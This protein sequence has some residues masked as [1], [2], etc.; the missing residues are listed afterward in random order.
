M[1]AAASLTGLAMFA[2]ACS[3]AY[4]IVGILPRII[5]KGRR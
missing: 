4:G 3:Y 2:L 1:L 5:Y